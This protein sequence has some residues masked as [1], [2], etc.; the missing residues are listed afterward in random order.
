MVYLSIFSM[1]F[2]EIYVWH[3]LLTF[4]SCD[5]GQY[6]FCNYFF[7]IDDVSSFEKKISFLIKLFSCMTKK[8][9]KR[10]KKKASE[11]E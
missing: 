2:K 5:I 6:V 4:T 10:R 3:C 7:R 9:E 11:V 8:E 1:I